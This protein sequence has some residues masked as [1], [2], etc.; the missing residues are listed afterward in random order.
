MNQAEI[1]TVVIIKSKTR[2]ELLTEKFNTAE[3]A[4]FY[5]AQSNMT[6][7]SK[8]S[9]SAG[10]GKKPAALSKVAKDTIEKQAF[11]LYQKEHDTFLLNFNKVVNT[12]QKLLKVKVLEKSFLPNYLFSDN[13]MVVVVG[14]D[15]LVANTA[16]YVKNNP[17]LGV[18][19]DVSR[20]DGV[21]LPFSPDTINFGIYNV[22][23]N[24]YKYKLVTMAKAELND[25]QQLL[26][27]N[28]LFIGPASHISARYR[29]EYKNVSENQSSSGIIITTGAGSTGWFSSLLNMTKRVSGFFTGTVPELQNRLDW[30]AN[31]LYFIVREPFL[32]RNSFINVTTG[33][34][35][36]QFQLEIESQMPENGIIFSDGVE[37]DFLKFNSG[38]IATISI[39]GQKAKLV[40]S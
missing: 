14:Q 40:I 28:D 9:M 15:G 27:F 19:P 31:Q 39:A 25:G 5:I 26:G 6:F 37:A 18:N 38:S 24:T 36:N 17:I 12:S 3:Q 23:N 1:D 22:L 33:I 35:D 11:D 34:I 32:S 29:I 21:L 16:K 10:G 20:Y 4:K 8:K 13:E 7:L 2:L 30:E